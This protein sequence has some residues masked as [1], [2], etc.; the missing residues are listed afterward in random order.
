MI[1]NGEKIKFPPL[2][3][4]I[5]NNVYSFG[6][7]WKHSKWYLIFSVINIFIVSGSTPINLVLTSRL[8]TM[9]DNGESF[10]KLLN[11]IFIMTLVSIV[12][13]AWGI[14]YRDLIIVRLRES[15]HLK[16]QSLFFEKTR[17]MELSRYDDP[18]F[19]NDFILTMQSADTYAEAS[20]NNITDIIRSVI[21]IS[22]VFGILAYID[23]QVLLVIVASSVLSIILD[24]KK[25]KIKFRE[26]VHFLPI[27]RKADYIVRVHKLADYAKELRMTDLSDK[28]ID[29]YEENTEEW[30][31]LAKKYGR[32]NVLFEISHLIDHQI[33]DFITIVIAMYKMVVVG[34]IELGGFAVI[35]N[36]NF[37]LYRM[38]KNFIRL[39][40]DIPQQSLY[41][42]KVRD[43]MEYIPK[44]RTGVLVAPEFEEIELQDV[45]FGY[46]A[47]ATV[48]H[49]INMKIR[50][51]EKIAIVGYNGAGKSTLIKLLMHL[52]QPND[53]AILY[54]GTDI[55]EY[56]T[57]SY[58]SHIGAVFQDYKLFAAT[59]GENVLGD[60]CK[61]T[62]SET[63]RQAL[64]IAT[65]DSK[66]ERL[67]GGI[68]TMLT[69]EFDEEGT[70]LSGGEAQKIAIARVFAQPY[71]IIIMDEPSSALDPIAEYKLNKHISEYTE[72]KTV[73]FISHRLSTTRH[74][75]RIYMLEEGRI[76]ETGSHD[77][78]MRLDG[79]YAR[80]FKVQ[81][82]KYCV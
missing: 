63:V 72:D 16:I 82:E 55:R 17:Q 10:L 74:V 48:L 78:L 76:I 51:G 13:L 33:L 2:R 79:K 56:E 58:R 73:I 9:L 80:M 28:L 61:D 35:I 12:T 31:M 71:E 45:S 69:R 68:N 66:L 8:F 46:N 18:E 29:D 4:I 53:G 44:G 19:Y 47:D 21:S 3:R 23:V 60:E 50:R 38:I 64:Q 5:Q 1:K 41:I 6:F 43:F 37:K 24:G 7:M 36:S 81:A 14:I 15:L 27:N 20:L 34:N 39:V 22:A 70:E 26:R 49:G 42:D 52:Y 40:T 32:K 62:D 67:P 65:F 54:N 77:E 30:I 25:K 57:D 59:I 75:D 11:I